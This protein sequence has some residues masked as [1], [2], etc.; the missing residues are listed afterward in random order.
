[1]DAALTGIKMDSN[2]N[3]T[4]EQIKDFK[5]NPEIYK[6]FVKRVEK[7][8]NSRFKWVNTPW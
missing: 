5:E 1:M 8:S 6:K 3:F 4:Q 7:S 2:N